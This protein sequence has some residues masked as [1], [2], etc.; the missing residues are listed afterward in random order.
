[1]RSKAFT[2]LA[3]SLYLLE[4]NSRVVPFYEKNGF[5]VYEKRETE[6]L[7]RVICMKYSI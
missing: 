1:M 3:C 6:K 5:V 7:G 2:S 4:K